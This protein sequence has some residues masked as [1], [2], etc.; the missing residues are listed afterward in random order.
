MVTANDITYETQNSSK[1]GDIYG[2]EIEYKYTSNLFNAGFNQAIY[3]THVDGMTYTPATNSQRFVFDEGIFPLAAS[4]ITNIFLTLNPNENYP[5]TLWYHYTG[6]KKR[7][8]VYTPLDNNTFYV[9]LG[10]D[11]GSV[12]A[13]DYLNITQQIKNIAKNTD[14]LIGIQNVFDKTQN[15]LYMPLN[16]R[17]SHDMRSPARYSFL[18]VLSTIDCIPK[19]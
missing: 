7:K 14:L 9:A 17:N 19:R 16:P 4:Y 5:T 6:S 15:N 11:N 18:S 10:R 3:H 2:V 13:Q 12:E 8:A 1:T